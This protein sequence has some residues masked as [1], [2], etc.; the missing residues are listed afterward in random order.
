M[1]PV[2]QKT[3]IQRAMASKNKSIKSF[4]DSKERSIAL[5]SSGRDATMMVAALSEKYKEL[6]EEDIQNKIKEWRKWFFNN[7]YTT[8]PEEE[9][10]QE[11]KMTAPPKEVLGF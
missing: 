4:Q 9:A 10:I 8:D 5:M 7:I 6:S 11:R 3:E 2:T 1:P